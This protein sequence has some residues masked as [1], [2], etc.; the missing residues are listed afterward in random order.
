ML[1]KNEV[2]AVDKLRHTSY[3]PDDRIEDRKIQ[4]LAE[5]LAKFGQIVPV[6]VMGE[7][8]ELIDGNRRLAAAKLVGIIELRAIVYYKTNRVEARN[9]FPEVND[10]H[11][12]HSSGDMIFE[13]HHGGSHNRP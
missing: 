8:L 3:N 11:R 10:K 7:T 5:S 12:R 6:L 9:L 1:V 13:E 2:I 4:T